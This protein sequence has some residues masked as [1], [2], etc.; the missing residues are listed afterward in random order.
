MHK[1]TLSIAAALVAFGAF[2]GSPAQA[3]SYSQGLACYEQ[4]DFS[5]AYRHWAPLAERGMAR[6]QYR[7]GSLY[8]EGTGVPRDMVEG[9]KWFALAARKGDRQAAEAMQSVA[10]IMTRDQVDEALD[11]A[12]AG[13]S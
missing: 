13:R 1:G 11:R 7:L 2:A 4:N 5:C 3:Q 10:E 9:Y 12:R 6:A 8:T